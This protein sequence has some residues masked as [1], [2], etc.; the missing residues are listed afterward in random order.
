MITLRVPGT[1]P[2]FPLLHA[3]QGT[4]FLELLKKHPMKVYLMNTGWVGG[5]AGVA[6][7]IPLKYNRATIQ[8]ILSGRIDQ[9][10]T[11]IDPTFGYA[12]PQRCGDVPPEL[13]TLR[14]TWKHPAD[15]DAKARE[16]AQG[17]VKNF[18][19]YAAAAPDIAAAGPRV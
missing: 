14:Q 15:Y 19:Q 2:F 9:A 18:A 3:Q 8:E 6:P 16:L 12:V 11:V 17:F 7:R 1:N 10:P 13:L 4:R 5:P